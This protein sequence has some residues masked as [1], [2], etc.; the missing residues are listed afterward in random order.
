MVAWY[1]M[2]EFLGMYGKP[3]A[4]YYGKLLYELRI[5]ISLQKFEAVILEDTEYLSGFLF[6]KVLPRKYVM[7]KKCLSIQTFSGLEPA[8]RRA[9][10]IYGV[11]K[12][13]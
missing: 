12:I 7:R 8:N 9:P 2:G 5:A 10:N 6:E 3:I 1:C 13:N 11:P 4:E